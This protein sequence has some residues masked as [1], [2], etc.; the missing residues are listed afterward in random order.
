[1]D[2]N[3][4]NKENLAEKFAKFGIPSNADRTLADLSISKECSQ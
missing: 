3:V 1:M 4:F 2:R